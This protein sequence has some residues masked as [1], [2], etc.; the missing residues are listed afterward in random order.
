MSDAGEVAWC[1]WRR[2]EHTH[3][4]WERFP[5]AD[6]A[7][8]ADCYTRLMEGSELA[9]HE[10][11]WEY[12]ILPAGHVPTSRRSSFTREQEQRYRHRMLRPG[13]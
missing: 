2:K 13:S 6:A 8:K 3:D 5:A 12:Q 11:Q 7:T 4:A 1:G 10:G 9:A